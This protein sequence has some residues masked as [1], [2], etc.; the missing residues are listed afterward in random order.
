MNNR[1]IVGFTLIHSIL[2]FVN[3]ALEDEHSSCL[4]EKQGTK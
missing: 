4:A 3:V 1:K 2:I